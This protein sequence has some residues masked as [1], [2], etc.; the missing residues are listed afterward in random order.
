VAEPG[1]GFVEANACRCGVSPE[2]CIQDDE[3]LTQHTWKAGRFNDQPREGERE[4]SMLRGDVSV[5][6]ACDYRSAG[7][8]V[9]AAKLARAGRRQVTAG[10]LRAAGLA[11]VHTPGRR[12]K[13]GIHVS[14]IW[15][16]DDPLHTQQVPWPAEVS[17]RFAACFN[18]DGEV[19]EIEP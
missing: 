14:I 16:P 5:A 17:E 8:R 10:K 1:E 9:A 19:D 11:V 13:N 7:V 18:E 6:E 2:L 12:V 3:L 15:P 4:L